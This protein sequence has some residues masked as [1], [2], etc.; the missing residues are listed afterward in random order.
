MDFQKLVNSNIKKLRLEK[1]L[2]QEQFAERIGKSARAI[3]KIECNYVMPSAQTINNICKEF[4]ILPD[5]LCR[6][7]TTNKSKVEV[8]RL[9]NSI[10]EKLSLVQ[11]KQILEIIKT[12]DK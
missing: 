4:G 3:S 5:V 2:T 12:F 10:L 7:T 11:L 9:I 1:G 6:S 8:L